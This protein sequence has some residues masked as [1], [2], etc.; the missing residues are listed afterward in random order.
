MNPKK[1]WIR[2]EHT[3]TD[4]PSIV[5]AC[6]TYL[7]RCCPWRVYVDVQR[8]FKPANILLASTAA[9]TCLKIADFGFAR[10]LAPALLAETLCGSPLYMVSEP[11]MQ[12]TTYFLTFSNVSSHDVEKTKSTIHIYILLCRKHNPFSFLFFGV[13]VYISICLSICLSVYLFVYLFVYLSNYLDIP[14]LSI[15]LTI[16]LSVGQ[17]KITAVYLRK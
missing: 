9:D 1:F 5:S 10:A 17:N 11:V 3:I 6:F 15:C 14:N 8:D 7:G 16:S 2:I 4:V 12:L 13:T